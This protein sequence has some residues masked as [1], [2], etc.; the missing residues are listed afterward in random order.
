VISLYKLKIT[1][2]SF[3]FLPSVFNL[4]HQSLA[5]FMTWL[6]RLLLTPEVLAILVQLFVFVLQLFKFGLNQAEVAQRLLLLFPHY[7]ELLALVL[8]SHLQFGRVLH[9][10]A[11]VLGVKSLKI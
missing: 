4:Q 5:A 10:L 1:C 2:K 11:V 6:L 3:H 8:V 7:F 9:S